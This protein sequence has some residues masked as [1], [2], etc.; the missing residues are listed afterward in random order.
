MKRFYFILAAV[1]VAVLMV[2]CGNKAAMR[3]QENSSDAVQ[4]LQEIVEG[5]NNE[6]PISLGEYLRVNSFEFIDDVVIIHYTVSTNFFVMSDVRAN[7]EAFRRNLLTGMVNNPNES[8]K[9]LADLM[10]AANAALRI[11]F[12]TTDDD[13]IEFNYTA[14]EINDAS[15]HS[16]NE[17]E[18]LLQ[19]MADNAELQTPQIIAEGLVMTSVYI[20]DKCF[21]YE[22]SCD[23]NI[24]DMDILDQS[25]ESVKEEILASLKVDD[26]IFNQL[27]KTIKE[28]NYRMAYKY[29][30]D[31]SGESVVIYIHPDEL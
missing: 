17:T 5:M 10:Q 2:A 26:P 15:M 6:C 28:C 12:C 1:A 4:Q 8:F 24:Y 13:C 31:T 3:V 23:E 20:K 25:K 30:G 19:T 27:R 14:D 7:K 21:T 16:N 11:V 9:T 29:V 18:V 22:Y